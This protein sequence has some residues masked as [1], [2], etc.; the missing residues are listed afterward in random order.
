MDRNG[1]MTPAE[2][3]NLLAR[4]I[5]QALRKQFPSERETLLF[6][7]AHTVL[8]EFRSAGI[9][10]YRKQMK[11]FHDPRQEIRVRRERR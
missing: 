9:G 1:R 10:C 7:V 6:Q 5:S 8:Q 2:G 11:D 4:L 3:R